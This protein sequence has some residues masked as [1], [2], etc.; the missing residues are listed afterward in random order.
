MRTRNA[1]RDALI[2]REG[3]A[4][5]AGLQRFLACV[6]RLLSERRL[7]RCAYLAERRSTPRQP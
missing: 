6:R 4:T 3:E 7:S 2:A 5:F 1:P